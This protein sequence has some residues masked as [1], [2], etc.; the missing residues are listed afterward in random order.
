[1]DCYWSCGRS[2]C[3]VGYC[4]WIC[5]VVDAQEEMQAGHKTVRN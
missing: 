1:M 3:A 4:S 5:D 2:C